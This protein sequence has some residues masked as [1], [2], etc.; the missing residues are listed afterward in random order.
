MP[1][2]PRRSPSVN[3]PNGTLVWRTPIKTRYP[4][5]EDAGLSALAAALAT[6]ARE[7]FGDLGDTVSELRR[8]DTYI[9]NH[10]LLALYGGNAA[11]YA[12]EAAS[13]FRAEPWR[14]ECGFGG[15]DRWCAGELIWRV[16]PHC[17]PENRKE[18]ERTIL[19][20]RSPSERE[21]RGVEWR[22]FARFELL[23]SFPKELRSPQ[24]NAHF[25]GL[26][27]RFG[28]P[29]GEPAA[30]AVQSVDS[31]IPHAVAK[32]MSDEDWLRAIA[33][34]DDDR[35]DRSEGRLTGGAPQLAEV[36]AAE[37]REDPERFALLFSEFSADTNVVYVKRTLMELE[38]A[39]I[40]T[41]LKVRVCRK[42]FSEFRGGCG[43]EIA[44]VLGS[45]EDS[46]PDEGVAMLHEI[47]T[48]HHDPPGDKGSDT[49]RERR[50]SSRDLERLGINTTRGRAALAIHKLILADPSYIARL[51]ST[52][53]GMI[54]DPSAAVLSW[55]AA[56]IGAVAT[57]DPALG[58]SL[59]LAADLFDD[60]LLDTT[61]VRRFLRWG[62]HEHFV[63]LRPVLDRML[64]SD[65]P[66]VCELGA[67]L[68]SI[69]VLLG[70]QDAE[71]LPEEARSGGPSASPRC[72]AGHRGQHR[73][74]GASGLGGGKTR[75]LL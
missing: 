5:V 47:M 6:L 23:S 4:D 48:R 59:F 74:S 54:R 22:G 35:I 42:A 24:A 53:E 75:R 68:V 64:R 45:A 50:W 25:E 41:A 28:E 57:H 8:R 66:E 39:A 13:M 46:L 34:Y 21:S 62:L 18:L 9:A 38:K 36:L 29:P 69:A 72:G 70:H 12:D 27:E 51:R 19:E 20:Y 14:F 40:A 63:E 60:H 65:E 37:A 17:T 2:W 71:D 16:A 15:N 67:R 1:L 26:R 61:H 11:R 33:K 49:H 7:G 31:P 3:D 52:M 32:S 10:L 44:D 56:V 73:C 43:M 30:Q 55:S 58:M